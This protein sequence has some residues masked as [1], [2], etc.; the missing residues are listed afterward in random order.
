[1]QNLPKQNGLFA[2]I[3]F[4]DEVID[5]LVKSFLHSVPQNSEATD[6]QHITAA[7]T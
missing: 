4:F 3:E 7:E 1:M 5:R 2:I 6:K